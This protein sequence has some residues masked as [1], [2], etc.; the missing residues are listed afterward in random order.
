MMAHLS[1]PVRRVTAIAL[2]VFVLVL[3]WDIVIEPM[4]SAWDD[5]NASYAQSQH[6]IASYRHAIEDKAKWQARAA[7]LRQG[8]ARGY[9]IDASDADLAGAKG[10]PLLPVLLKYR[11]SVISTVISSRVL[12]DQNK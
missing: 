5:A 3:L 9:F 8:D 10:L 12:C 1:L 6:A 4:T 2:P 11:L 7:Q